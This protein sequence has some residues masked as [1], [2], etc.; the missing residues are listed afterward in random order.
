MDRNF[1]FHNPVKYI[2][3][4]GEENEEGEGETDNEKENDMSPVLPPDLPF[5]SPTNA[6][7]SSE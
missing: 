7:Q 3:P 2:E 1:D 4:V 5:I 6:S